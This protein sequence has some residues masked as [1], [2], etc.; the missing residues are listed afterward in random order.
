M[1]LV[2]MLIVAAIMGVVSI[3][4]ATIFSNA[5]KK[6]A[7]LTAKQSSRE[8][9]DEIEYGLAS[10]NCGLPTNFFY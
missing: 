5:F 8:F 3:G 4:F 10:Y 2:E 9:R 6:E 7:N 1:T